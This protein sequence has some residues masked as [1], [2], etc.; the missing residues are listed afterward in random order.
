MNKAIYF[1]GK[2]AAYLENTAKVLMNTLKKQ[3]VAVHF[4]SNNYFEHP[5]IDLVVEVFRAFWNS[6]GF[7][8]Y[9]TITTGQESKEAILAKAT[10][11]CKTTEWCALM[12][13]NGG[14]KEFDPM[15]KT[16]GRPG[17]MNF[18]KDNDAEVSKY[19][20]FPYV[21][22]KAASQK[23]SISAESESE[24]PEEFTPEVKAEA[25]RGLKAHYMKNAGFLIDV[26]YPAYTKLA[27]AEKEMYNSLIG[28]KTKAQNVLTAF[29]T[30]QDRTKEAVKGLP[31]YIIDET[32]SDKLF[33]NAVLSV[34]LLFIG[35]VNGRVNVL[36]EYVQ[37]DDEKKNEIIIF[38][39]Q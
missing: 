9:Q 3:G 29:I 34:S 16:V 37:E 14:D 20:S 1:T 30:L 8:L 13:P 4:G 17:V 5:N 19:N 38:L 18:F 28:K 36:K 7:E 2:Q 21:S 27:L 11:C 26:L 35:M 22:I 12:F 24:E 6:C 25:L 32:E 10:A 31:E 15:M 33:C 23:A 39:K